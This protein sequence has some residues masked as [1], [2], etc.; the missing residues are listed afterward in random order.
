MKNKNNLLLGI[1]IFLSI[2]ILFKI[3]DFDS[4]TKEITNQ[5]NDV[6]TKLEESIELVKD[7][8]KEIDLLLNKISSD[9]K[10]E[11]EILE[12]EKE[13]IVKTH[14]INKQKREA[15]LKRITKKLE[16]TKLEY[17]DILKEIEDDI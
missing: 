3:F 15:E 2:S 16:H 14:T 6:Q 8:E 1:L 11:I 5:L 13:K 17:N 4:K 9:Y 10:E 12:K 7:T